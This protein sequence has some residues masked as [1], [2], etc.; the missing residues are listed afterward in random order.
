LRLIHKLGQKRSGAPV[1]STLE[2]SLQVKKHSSAKTQ[3]SSKP[4]S[5]VVNK[6]ETPSRFMASECRDVLL[7]EEEITSK[8][9]TE[10]HLSFRHNGPD[11][12][13]EL[14]LQVCAQED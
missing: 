2:A 6:T 5:K 13:R 10:N 14:E 3:R 4:E 11:N 9:E 12:N 8:T 7:L 1:G